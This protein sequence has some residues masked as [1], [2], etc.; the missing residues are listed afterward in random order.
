MPLFTTTYQPKNTAQIFGQDLSLAQVKNF[1]STYKTQKYRAILIE[2]PNGCGKTASIVALAKELDY[3]LLELNSSEDRSE[4][5]VRSF[6]NNS[7]NQQSLFFRP[8]I[9]LLDEVDNVSGTLDRGAVSAIVDSITKSKF[10]IILTANDTSDSKFKPLQKACLKIQY[11]ELDY[12]AIAHTLLWVCEQEKIKTDEKTINSLARQSGGDLR[13]ALIDLQILSD[14]GQV[15]YDR[16]STLTPRKRTETIFNA[17]TLIF[18]SSKVE[19]A[20]PALDDIDVEMNEVFLWLDYNL[21]FEYTNA[22]SLARAYESLSRADIFQGR[23]MKR[24]HW[25]FLSYVTNL[26]T[27]GISSAKSERNTAFVQYKQ[28]MRL[29]KIWQ[30]K[31]KNGKRKEIAQRL[32][33]KCHMSKHIAFTQVPYLSFMLKKNPQLSVELSLSAEETDYLEENIPTTH[34]A[35]IKS[36]QK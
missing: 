30:M 25:R 7:L 35:A 14:S 1:I 24:Q 27:A 19:N 10:P 2:G 21:P 17:L 12:K 15:T 33:Q 36:L 34:R 32:A 22:E 9:I 11:N 29:L 23:I 26:L 5:A 8:K 20:L 13:S 3:D 16:L 18:K 4:Q 31:Q 6:L 28:T